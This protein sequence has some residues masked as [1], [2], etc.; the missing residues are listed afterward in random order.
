[1]TAGIRLLYS[2]IGCIVKRSDAHLATSFSIGMLSLTTP[3]RA[4]DAIDL[5][6]QYGKDI[7]YGKLNATEL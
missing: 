5:A 2:D 3:T 4:S 7:I 6:T 1:M